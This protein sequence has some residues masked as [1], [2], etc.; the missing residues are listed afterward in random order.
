MP[1][2]AAVL[3]THAADTCSKPLLPD[4]A[5]QT[6]RHFHPRRLSARRAGWAEPPAADLR[7]LLGRA[8]PAV[9]CPAGFM[10]GFCAVAYRGD[11]K[12]GVLARHLAGLLQEL[13][14]E[15]PVAGLDPNQARA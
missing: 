2:P 12:E 11:P 10:R 15:H 14:E 9:R 3:R 8:L 4:H 5:A 6:F 13:M 7:Y 1:G